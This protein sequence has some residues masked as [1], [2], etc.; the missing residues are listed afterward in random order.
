MFQIAQYG[1]VWLAID[2]LSELV[3]YTAT[4]TK[5]CKGF[6]EYSNHAHEVDRLALDKAKNVMA[7]YYPYGS[8]SGLTSGDRNAKT[9]QPKPSLGDRVMLAVQQLGDQLFERTRDLIAAIR[10]I[11]KCSPTPLYKFKEVWQ[12]LLKSCNASSSNEYSDF[13][14]TKIT[15][16]ENTHNAEM[17]TESS[18][19]ALAPNEVWVAGEVSFSVPELNQ[20]N[21]EVENLGFDS[22]DFFSFDGGANKDNNCIEELEVLPDNEFKPIMTF[23]QAVAI[24]SI[25]KSEIGGASDQWRKPKEP[26]RQNPSTFE[27]IKAIV[28]ADPIRARSELAML[29]AKLLIPSVK[30][31]ERSQTEQA[32]AWLEELDFDYEYF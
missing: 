28:T 20:Q 27:N 31:E 2:D 8:K 7:T 24:A 23:N 21:A 32:I 10:A 14:I 4:Q 16:Q 25:C 17:V 11:A 13:D 22:L 6:Y 18:V 26:P 30:G 5:N 1:R 12:P 3:E 19:T 9:K 15:N 29:K